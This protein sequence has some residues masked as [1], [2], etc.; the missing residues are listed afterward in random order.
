[1]NDPNIS[2]VSLGKISSPTLI[3]AGTND[4]IKRSHTELIAVSI[5]NAKLALIDGDH[6]VAEKNPDEFN[7]VVDN[8]LSE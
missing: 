7:A 2:P 4:L 8:F 5:P 1:M 6:F 3:I